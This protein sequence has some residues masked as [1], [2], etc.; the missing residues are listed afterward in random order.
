[1]TPVPACVLLS[2]MFCSN[3]SGFLS[4]STYMLSS[5][6]SE[7]SLYCAHL[8]RTSPS[9]PR[10]LY[11]CFQGRLRR[12]TCTSTQSLVRAAT[13]T[14]LVQ[15]TT[16]TTVLTS[17]ASSVRSQ[18]KGLIL[19]ETFHNNRLCSPTPNMHSLSPH[20][21]NK[22]NV[23]CQVLKRQSNLFIFP[24]LDRRDFMKAGTLSCSTIYLL[25]PIKAFMVNH[26]NEET[27]LTQWSY[28]GIRS[29]QMSFINMR[30]YW[31]YILGRSAYLLTKWMNGYPRSR[32][33]DRS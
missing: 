1:M 31:R 33:L 4:K 21:T 16:W 13:L 7:V 17:P 10:L 28:L 2:L 15:W 20:S 11:S 14:P 24:L 22:N 6:H 23:R 30:S 8:V 32:T 9:L 19:R 3:H 29:L 26:E 18:L 25:A 5:Y 27:H 12:I